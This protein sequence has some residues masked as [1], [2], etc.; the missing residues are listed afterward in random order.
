MQL[1]APPKFIIG[2]IISFY[3]LYATIGFL[4]YFPLGP[5]GLLVAALSFFPC[6]KLCRKT[7]KWG[8][9]NHKY[10]QL[11][12]FG[13]NFPCEIISKAQLS[14]K[15]N[16]RNDPSLLNV[17][18]ESTP[19]IQSFKT[20]LNDIFSCCCRNPKFNESGFY[21]V[22]D[23][24]SVS[25]RTL[26]AAGKNASIVREIDN[27]MSLID[28]TREDKSVD[29]VDQSLNASSDGTWIAA[30][31][32][33]K[34]GQFTS[35]INNVPKA[36]CPNLTPLLGQVLGR[37]L[38]MFER[39]LSAPIANEEKL[40]VYVKIKVHIFD[41]DTKHE[42]EGRFH[43]EGTE[44]E[45]ICAVGLYWPHIDSDRLQGGDIELKFGVRYLENDFETDH[46]FSGRH[47][48]TRTLPVSSGSM[49]VFN[50]NGIFH[51]MS[52]LSPNGAE[53]TQ[54]TA[55]RYVVAFFLASPWA[56]KVPSSSKHPVVTRLQ[57]G[58]EY[59]AAKERRNRE[60]SIKRD[61]ENK[62][63]DEALCPISRDDGVIGSQD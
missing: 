33:A 20:I 37:M 14:V 62:V 41:S 19:R 28:D 57:R 48:V 4:V 7:S 18:Q 6:L 58:D 45:D 51:R 25:C 40:R 59:F 54:A 34:I 61:S 13:P 39:L 17:A 3:A 35:D 11:G 53:A 56:N 16:A 42:S 55:R 15:R 43:M 10:F 49:A 50:N 63:G 21:D 44:K 36:E 24:V 1:A 23:T 47:I 29:V 2:F 30:D 52:A 46:T 60:R 26:H 12:K 32:N 5:L 31:Y 22:Y 8:W 9:Y 38:P 27:L